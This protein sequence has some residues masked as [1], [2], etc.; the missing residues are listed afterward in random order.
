M[1]EWVGP[2]IGA[3]GVLF[4]RIDRREDK[5]QQRTDLLK[6]LLELYHRVSEW[7]RFAKVTNSKLAA[8]FHARTQEERSTAASQV[9][10]AS[11]LQYVRAVDGGSWIGVDVDV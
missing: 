3:V 5:L 4:N 9:L 8:W 10:Y 7:E 2:L 1:V 11:S 6:P